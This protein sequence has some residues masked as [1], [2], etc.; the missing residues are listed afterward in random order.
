VKMLYPPVVSFLL[1]M[2]FK[3]I[4]NPTIKT[5]TEI[6][7]KLSDTGYSEPTR[8]RLISSKGPDPQFIFAPM[9]FLSEEEGDEI[10]IFRDS[11]Y[12]QYNEKYPT[13]D[14]ILP[15]ILENFFFLSEKLKIS[16]IES[17]SLDYIDL[18][19]KFPQK[20]FEIGSY[21]NIRLKHPPEFEMDYNDF[22][23]GVKLKT[24]DSNHK[25]I[26]RIRGLKTENDE[27][28]KIQLETRYLIIE[29]IDIEEKERFKENLNIAHD[30]LLDNFKLVL[31]EKTK[32][33]LV[34]E[35]GGNS[36]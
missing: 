4:D 18:F 26:L 1:R 13:W 15:N 36:E 17:I 2:N 7:E 5:L 24:E 3:D 33:I 19:D 11:I 8:I 32:K 10:L 35:N 22:I 31:T 29:A 16:L 20:G 23:I 28:C 30:N 34:M 6:S 12:F 14:K 27:N 9:R 25:S 21:F